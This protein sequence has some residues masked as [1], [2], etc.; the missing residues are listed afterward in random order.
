ME[1]KKEMKV[2]T[3][4]EVKGSKAFD[5]VINVENQHEAIMLFS[6][7]NTDKVN[8]ILKNNSINSEMLKKAIG[9]ANPTAKNLSFKF[10]F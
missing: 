7:F 3:V 10:H 8:K 5:L 4:K 9:E 1:G 2:R 6:L